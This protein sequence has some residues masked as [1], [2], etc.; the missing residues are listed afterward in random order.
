MSI[1]SYTVG[2]EKKK[3]NER[4]TQHLVVVQ[5][6]P[7]VGAFQVRGDDVRGLVAQTHE[8]V[9]LR[10]GLAAS[11]G[12][13]DEEKGEGERH[14]GRLSRRGRRSKLKRRG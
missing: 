14:K 3:G 7:D 12:R 10:R 2:W 13:R 4:E 9:H 8:S 5:K 1:T 11:S 6:A